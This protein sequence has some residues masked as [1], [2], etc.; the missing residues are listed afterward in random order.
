MGR[1]AHH[2]LRA[3]LTTAFFVPQRW[4]LDGDGHSDH[5][6]P[7]NPWWCRYGMRQLKSTVPEPVTVS[8]GRAEARIALRALALIRAARHARADE[9]KVVENIR[10][11]RCRAIR[12]CR[13]QGH[14][15][16]PACVSRAALEVEDRLWAV[17]SFC[18]QRCQVDL[19]RAL[20]EHSLAVV[21]VLVRRA[22]LVETFGLAVVPDGAGDE[23]GP[24]AGITTRRRK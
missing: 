1:S 18:V 8:I 24:A 23:D 2:Q 3:A 4:H 9:R 5:L 11:R 13:R 7:L 20:M 15:R 12:W 22:V 16:A 17:S 19:D 10:V 21:T 6:G 14:W